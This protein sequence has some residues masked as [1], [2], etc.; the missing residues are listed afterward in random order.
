MIRILAI[1][2]IERYNSTSPHLVYNVSTFCDV[3]I[4][5]VRKVFFRIGTDLTGLPRGSIIEVTPVF[6]ALTIQIPFSTARNTE[7]E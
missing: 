7:A 3:S 1:K 5:P 6:P 2:S 4:S